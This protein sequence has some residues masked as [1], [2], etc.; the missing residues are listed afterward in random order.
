MDYCKEV[1]SQLLDCNIYEEIKDFSWVELNSRTDSLLSSLM[2]RGLIGKKSKEHL[3]IFIYTTNRS[4][5]TGNRTRG[6]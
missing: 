6:L 4:A 5:T 1:M 2:P 3:F